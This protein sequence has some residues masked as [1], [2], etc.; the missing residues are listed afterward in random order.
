VTLP[1]NPGYREFDD[2]YISDVL[3]AA[4]IGIKPGTLANWRCRGRGP[5]YFKVGHQVL[6]RPADVDDW[7]V[8]QRHTHEE[9]GL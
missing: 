9:P 7:I 5:V 3:A 2:G 4:E 1:D 8:A 6:Y